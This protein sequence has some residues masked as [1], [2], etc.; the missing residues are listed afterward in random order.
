MVPSKCSVPLHTILS[1]QKYHRNTV[2]LCTVNVIQQPLMHSVIYHRML[3][4][5]ILYF[6]K[7]SAGNDRLIV[8]QQ[9]SPVLPK[10]S[11]CVVYLGLESPS[12][13]APPWDCMGTYFYLLAARH[14]R[15]WYLIA[16]TQGLKSLLVSPANSPHPVVIHKV[17]DLVFEPTGQAKDPRKHHFVVDVLVDLLLRW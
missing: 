14:I 13:C 5:R 16:L 15:L 12:A 3:V 9:H 6:A 10:S 11:C 7:D 17:P 1:D 8:V 4:R 2:P